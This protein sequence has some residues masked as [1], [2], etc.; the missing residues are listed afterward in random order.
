MKKILLLLFVVVLGIIAF[1]YFRSTAPVPAP[2]KRIPITI[3]TDSSSS[4]DTTIPTLRIF[5]DKPIAN[6]WEQSKTQTVYYLSIDGK[7][8]KT[9]GDGRD[10]EASKQIIP[11]L[12]SLVP[13]FDGSRALASFN[14]PHEE[15]FAVFDTA[16]NTWG[17]LPNNTIAATFDPSSTRVAYLLN[18]AADSGLYILNLG[19]LKST[20][21]LELATV[22]GELQWTRGDEIIFRGAPSS[23]APLPL[24]SIDTKKKTIRRVGDTDGL[25]YSFARDADLGLK[26]ARATPLKTTL[27]LTN[28]S[29]VELLNFLF[30]TLPSKCAFTKAVVYCAVPKTFPLR[31]NLPD[32]YLKEKIFTE[33]VFVSYDIETG[34]TTTLFEPT[35]SIDATQLLVRNNGK[36]LLFK[37]HYDEKMYALTLPQAKVVEEPEVEGK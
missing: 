2:A 33:D 15:S 13:S 11:K 10:E 36:E 6:F 34:I 18:K 3:E 17:R 27:A 19:D 5:D 4:Q 14:Y 24:W 29:G 7:V 30:L 25:M 12:H 32:D 22:S 23:R 20:K 21:I 31:A 26:L 8:F 9:F 28:G 1:F 37:N 35:S 16:N